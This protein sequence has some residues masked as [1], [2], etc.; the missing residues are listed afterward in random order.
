VT[1]DDAVAADLE[2]A[3]ARGCQIDV[4]FETEEDTGPPYE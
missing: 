2:A 1:I 4:V 3:V